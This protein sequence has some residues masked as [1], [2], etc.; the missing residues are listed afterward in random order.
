MHLYS[1]THAHIHTRTHTRAHTQNIHALT[2][3]H[4]Q[5]CTH[6]HTYMCSHTHTRTHCIT[7]VIAWAK[8]ALCTACC[9]LTRL[10][11]CDCEAEDEAAVAIANAL[12]PE[13]SLTVLELAS[14]QFTQKGVVVR[15]GLYQTELCLRGVDECVR[16]YVCATAFMCVLGVCV[17]VCSD[18]RHRVFATMQK[19]GC[20]RCSVHLHHAEA[21]KHA[22]SLSLYLSLS[23]S[24]SLSASAAEKKLSIVNSFVTERKKCEIRS[25]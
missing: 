20:C 13:G 19:I 25:L 2:H 18:L 1:H 8:E 9:G 10:T 5:A 16:V 22:L 4:T 21:Y 15:S 24:L 23:L 17:C 12:R 3:S 7:G 11:L 14:N 6:T